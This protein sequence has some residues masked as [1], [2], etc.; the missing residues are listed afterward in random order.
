MTNTLA[1]IL[2]VAL[3]AAPKQSGNEWPTYGNDPGG[4]RHSPLSQINRDNVS[5]VAV[6]WTY[7]TGDVADG[8]KTAV[9]SGFEATP[10]M[11]DGTLYFSTPFNRVI[12]LDPAT[13]KERW[14]FDP[15]IDRSAPY[16]DGFISRGVA[17][18]RDSRAPYQRRI[19]AATLDSRL[20]ALDAATGKRCDEFGKHGEVDLSAGVTG[21]ANASPGEY[22]MTSSP[23]VIGELVL[24]GSSINDNSR[25]E[26]PSGVVRAFDARTGALRWSWDPIPKEPSSGAANAWSMISVDPERGLVFVPTGSASPDYFGGMRPGA[27][28]DAN[29]VVA[30]KAATGKRVW[31]FQV[32]HHDLWDYDVPSQPSLITLRRDSREIAA[33][34]VSTKMGN[35]FVLDRETGQPLFPIEERRVPE[36]DVA[37][38]HASPTQPFPA[39]LSPLVPQNKITA[40]E[41]WGATPEDKQWCRQR[42]AQLRS[43]GIF[44]PPSLKGTIVFPGNVGGVNWGG[45]T[46]DPERTLVI[47]A[48]N[49]LPFVI[50]LVPRE[51]A[52]DLKAD[53]YV[54]LASMKKTPFALKR[55]ALITPRF[56][57][58][59]PP[60]WGALSGLDLSTGKIRWEVPL[61]SMPEAAKLSGADG[62][63]SIN[64]G[65]PMSTAGGLVFVAAGRD[66][67][68]RAMDIETGKELWKAPLPASAQ[69]TPMTYQIGG[70]QYVVIAAGGHP[71]LPT[72]QGDALVAFA[73]P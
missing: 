13:G 28:A 41:T 15:K 63:G 35:V 46:Y 48:T 40:D 3:S 60:P 62:F 24:V 44:T 10:I 50:T 54:E 2:A 49:R 21:I 55:V 64:L 29:S 56:T 12:A 66:T 67:N 16:G 59:N 7:H 20:I 72:K 52:K 39:F 27:N 18:W 4:M 73:L 6:A 61:G 32:V 19:F 17:T 33:V 14:T 36:S 68:F 34:V 58:C 43:E 9:K 45:V 1:V 42:I 65:G 47:A 23:A 22:H 57:L 71:K 53:Q 5:S 8:S 37:G 69:S 26:M 31:G 38:E 30:L 25:A 70:K 11:V 51:D